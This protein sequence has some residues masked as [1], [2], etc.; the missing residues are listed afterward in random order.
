MSRLLYMR[1]EL[2]RAFR[3]RRFFIFSFGFP[4]VLYFLIAAPQRNNHDLAG[5]GIS[6]PLYYMVGLAA[7]GTMASMISSGGRIAA[8]RQAGWTRQLRITPLRPRDY[9]RA[10]VVTAYAM[11]ITSLLLLYIA[12]ASLGV[13]L[14]A[15]QW[16]AMTGL[17][18]IALLPLAALGITLGHLV[19]VESI[20]PLTGGLVAI[21]AFL[22][23]TWFPLTSGFLYDVG[24][25]LPGYWIVQASHIAIHGHGWGTKGWVVVIAWTVALVFLARFAY[26][27]DTQRV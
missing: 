6:A 8:E 23:G 12:G 19:N 2:L 4:L 22:S 17:I 1:L 11:A 26:R 18:L 10:K 21:L 13:R 16:L 27:R 20:G 9:F 14:P 15:H 3:N 24:Q 7:F 5:T 25:Y